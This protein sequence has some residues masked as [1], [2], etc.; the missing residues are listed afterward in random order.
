MGGRTF[1]GLRCTR[2]R[3]VA[4]VQEFFTLFSVRVPSCS[5]RKLAEDLSREDFGCKQTRR[6]LLYII[7]CRSVLVTGIISYKCATLQ[8][9]SRTFALEV[10]L[11][12]VVQS[13]ATNSKLHSRVVYFVHWW[14]QQ[15]SPIRRA[16]LAKYFGGTNAQQHLFTS[17]RERR[18][19]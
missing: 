2:L 11:H 18:V 14:S 19:R 4:S 6:I 17:W 8:A 12:F 3:R 5:D 9:V 1:C 15:N 13:E 16:E 10:W 7:S